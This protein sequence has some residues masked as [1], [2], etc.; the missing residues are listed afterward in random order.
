MFRVYQSSR[1]DCRI[2]LSSWRMEITDDAIVAIHQFMTKFKMRY[3]YGCLLDNI[4]QDKNCVYDMS[5]PVIQLLNP[6]FS[7]LL[8]SLFKIILFP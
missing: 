3:F 2:E 4:R 7:L 8:G 5:Y 1:Y 6:M